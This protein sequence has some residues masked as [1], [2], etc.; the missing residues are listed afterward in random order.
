[1]PGRPMAARNAMHAR[2]FTGL[3]IARRARAS[4][5]SCAAAGQCAFKY[6]GHE[7]PAHNRSECRLP[8]VCWLG[9][10]CCRVHP[11][12]AVATWLVSFSKHP[13]AERR[14]GPCSQCYACMPTAMFRMTEAINM[15]N[16]QHHP[17]PI[18]SESYGGH[19]LPTLA[20]ALLSDPNP[21]P[22]F[23]F[24]GFL[25]GNPL[26]YMPYRNYGEFGT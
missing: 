3:A 20:Q 5:S 21:D 4:S 25:V 12:H 2:A 13:P 14:C 6:T 26:T 16:P 18:F 1:M 22:T 9:R 23:A 19:Y 17:N 24:K 11:N 8:V 15:S 7:Q 10:A